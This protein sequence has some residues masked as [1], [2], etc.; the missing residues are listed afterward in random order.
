[1]LLRKLVINCARFWYFSSSPAKSLLNGIVNASILALAFGSWWRLRKTD[2]ASAELLALF[3]VA[4]MLLYA[5]V[6]VHSSRFSLPIVMA[7]LPL[8]TSPVASAWNARVGGHPENT[9]VD[10]ES[11]RNAALT[12][13]K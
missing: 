12:G 10:T 5:G 1:L 7:L 6:I 2:R 4:I 9:R 11:I 3:I 13:G 8:A